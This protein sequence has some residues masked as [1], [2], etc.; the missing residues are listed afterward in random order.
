MFCGACNKRHC[1]S[2]PESKG[3]TENLPIYRE[4]HEKVFCVRWKGISDSFIQEKLYL[5]F[6]L[7]VGRSVTILDGFDSPLSYYWEKFLL[8]LEVSEKYNK[9]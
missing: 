7:E 2:E 3:A 9:I 5:Q 1:N 6:A 4:K 8:S